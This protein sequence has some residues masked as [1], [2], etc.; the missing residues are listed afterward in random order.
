MKIINH[1][2]NG[3]QIGQ[4]RED[5]YINLTKM[6]K[7]NGKKINDYLRLETTKAFIDELFLVAGIPVSKI[8]QVKKGRGNRVEQGTWGHPQVAIH[9]GQWCSAK[10][11]VLVSNWVV[12]W[13]TTGNNSISSQ[14]TRNPVDLLTELEQLENLVISIRSQTRI[15]HT[16]SHQPADDH[17][18][19]SLHTISHNQLSIINSA[20]QRLQKL[21]Q[22]AEMNSE[23]ETLADIE[24]PVSKPEP[25]E[26]PSAKPTMNNITAANLIDSIPVVTKEATVRFTVDLPESMYRDLSILAA[27]RGVS[28]ADLVR[29]LL[30]DALENINK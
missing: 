11:A 29:M 27:K 28:K 10:F 19:K 12:N 7:A 16:G 25:T 23:L 15:F 21:K 22:V 18:V 17:L 9:C 2:V 3:L 14:S 30:N 4:R 6:A 24:I 5:G 1:E 13:M 20:I 26:Q 8:I